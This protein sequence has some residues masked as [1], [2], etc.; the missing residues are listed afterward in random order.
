MADGSRGKHL[1]GCSDERLVRRLGTSSSWQAWTEFLKRFTPLIIRIARQF[2]DQEE[3]NNECYLHVTGA[4]ARDGFKRLRAYDPARGASLRTWLS[5]VVFNL[6]VDWHRKQFGRA[7][8]LPA[9]SALPAFDQQVYRYRFEQGLGTRDCLSLLAKDFPDVSREQLAQAASRVH[10]VLTPRQRWQASVRF[11]RLNKLDQALDKGTEGRL[12]RL[13]APGPDPSETTE[14]TQQA[15]QLQAALSQLIPRQ[16]ILLKLR[17][18]HGLSLQKIA[19]IQSDNDA[20]DTWRQVQ[21]ALDELMR[22]LQDDKAA[23]SRKK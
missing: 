7:R 12:G 16:Q 11:S 17:Y 22:I 18:T 8:L 23:K 2:D 20:A 4:L 3:H 6:C 5:A 13:P 10:Q 15:E 1:S 21:K 9:I 14:R 19:E